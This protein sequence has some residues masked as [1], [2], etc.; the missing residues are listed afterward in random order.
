MILGSREDHLE[1][2]LMFPRRLVFLAHHAPACSK[3]HYPG[4]RP[5]GWALLTDVRPARGGGQG[6]SPKWLV[7]VW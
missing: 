5:W 1:I 3:Q 6:P 7:T 2:G 4:P